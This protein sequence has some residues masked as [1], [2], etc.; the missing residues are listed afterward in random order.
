MT[1]DTKD[2]NRRMKILIGYDGSES[3]A[4]A[5]RDLSR[6]GMPPAGAATVLSSVDHSAIPMATYSPGAQVLADFSWA[7]PAVWQEAVDRATHQA[8]QTAK[9]GTTLLQ[10]VLPGWEVRSDR[11]FDSPH[12]AY[13]GR[14]EG[15]C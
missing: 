8:E 6:A 9:E 5:I 7:S 1:P 11:S 12:D 2:A 10:S 4:D 15:R 14:G 13:R 3:A